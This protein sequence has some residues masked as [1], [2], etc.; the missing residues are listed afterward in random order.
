M[1]GISHF[2]LLKTNNKDEKGQVH[3]GVN[4]SMILGNL[5]KTI[6][7]FTGLR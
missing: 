2:I 6:E 5:P 4:I 1:P 7:I 3:L